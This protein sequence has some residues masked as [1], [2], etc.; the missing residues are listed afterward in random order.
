MTSSR[1]RRPWEAG[2]EVSVLVEV[3]DGDAPVEKADGTG[4]KLASTQD[5][6][7]VFVDGKKR[8]KLP[9]EL[10]DLEP[11][12]VKLRFE[13]DEH[14]EPLEKTVDVKDGEIADIG[15]IK[16]KVIKGD[17]ILDLKTEGAEVRLIGEGDEKVEKR[18]PA[19]LWKKPP[20][21]LEDLDPKQKWKIVATKKG[22]DDFEEAVT[23]DDGKAEVE[24]AIELTKTG[25]EVSSAKPPPGPAPGPGPGPGPDKPPP[26]PPAG[27]NGTLNINSI[28]VSKVLLD[29]RPLGSTPK[30]GISVS[31]GSH[32]VTFIHPEKGRKSLSVTVKAGQTKTAAVKFK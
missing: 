27:G 5:D 20:V 11:G 32:T 22:Y 30:V 12:S 28:P 25:E 31:A 3:D 6:V 24:L 2:K 23:F 14:Y 15:E 21:R 19:S 18:L 13:G 9:V 8:G 4:V 10:T 17:L 26:P 16:L 7:T 1:L 29:G